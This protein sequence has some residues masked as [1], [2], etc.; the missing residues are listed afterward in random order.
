MSNE[1]LNRLA[2]E[3]S[4]EYFGRPFL[5]KASFNQR[6]RTTGGRY[7][8]K[9]GMIEIN[10][11]VFALYGREELI[12]ILKHELCHYHLHQQGEGHFHRDKSFKELLAEVGGARYVR[13]LTTAEEEAYRYHLI[14][15]KCGQSY[16]RKRRL[17]VRKHRCGKCFGK[18]EL[19]TLDPEVIDK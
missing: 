17:D 8:L 18:I 2:Q 19:I 5:H 10:Y 12:S 1:E 3:I 9:T 15:R 4:L 7:F 13:P 14:C 6:L 11:R 16:Y